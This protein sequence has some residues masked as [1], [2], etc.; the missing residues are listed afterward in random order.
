MSSGAH[1]L[2]TLVGEGF[3]VRPPQ[4]GETERLVQLITSDPGASPWWGSDPVV[5]TR[6]IADDDVNVL[7]IVTPSGPIGLITFTEEEDPSYFSAS[8]DIGL[9]TGT[10]GRGVGTAA[11]RLLARWL[12][13]VRGHHRITID[14]AVANER[15]VAV[16]HKVGFKTIG[17][18]RQYEASPSG[19]WHD[20]LLMDLLADD[21]VDAATER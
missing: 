18:A 1:A 6:W 21:L 8:I 19:G 11:L 9:L 4:T 2:P 7:V 12:F 17:V 10:T 5:I 14:P 3:E 13:D 16:Y 20:N 15:A